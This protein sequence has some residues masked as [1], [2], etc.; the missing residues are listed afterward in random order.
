MTELQP[1]ELLVASLF[2][3][4]VLLAVVNDAAELRIPNIISAA[5]V[6]LYPV[7]VAA[8]GG[9]AA[10]VSALAIAL[11]V[12]ALGAVAFSAGVFGGGDV[13]LLAALAL[14]CGP[15]AVVPFL[16]LTA[17]F[18][19]LIALVMISDYR[20]AAAGALDLVGEKLFRNALMGTSIPYGI[21][22]GAAGLL[23]AGTAL[24]SSGG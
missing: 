7:H 21:A 2:C 16:A 3:G 4:L 1:I 12:F 5:L 23:T 11:A 6:A 24:L 17:L 8:K 13:K 15:G 10:W 19:G 20:F 9:D 22:I 18:G 14:W